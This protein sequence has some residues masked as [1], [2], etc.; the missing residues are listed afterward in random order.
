MARPAVRPPAGRTGTHSR[1]SPV[2][3]AAERHA[4]PPSHRAG[5][6]ASPGLRR[7]ARAATPPARRS[8]PRSPPASAPGRESTSAPW[9]DA[10]R[11][12]GLDSGRLPGVAA[13]QPDPAGDLRRLGPQDQ[14][15]VRERRLRAARPP[16]WRRARFAPGCPRRSRHQGAR[17]PGRSGTCRASCLVT[18]PGGRPGAACPD[19]HLSSPRR[20][21]C[22]TASP[23]PAELPRLRSVV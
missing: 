7:C 13:D 15:Q 12:S 21:S 23:G 19:H 11:A 2:P 22:S 8:P 10:G 6:A 16:V 5:L 3:Q 4:A 18:S 20:T 14:G 17:H 1:S 9:H